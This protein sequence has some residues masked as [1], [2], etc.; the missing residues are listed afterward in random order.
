MPS[1]TFNII[2]FGCRATQ[3][4]GAALEEAFLND[5]YQKAVQWRHSDIVVINTC[6]VTH[7]ADAEARAMIRRVHRE[8][9]RARLV[10]TG[11]YAQRAPGDLAAIEGVSCVI[12]NSH[13]DQLVSILT[14]SNRER[15]NSAE[16]PDDKHTSASG[17]S[18]YCSSIFESRELRAIGDAG[19]AGRTR[20]VL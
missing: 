10:V 6:T 7:A 15:E 18:V 16:F 3:A 13:K 5:S 14:R 11:C 2:N 1:T 9:P 17:A 20:P 12:G 8:N 19:G 4:D